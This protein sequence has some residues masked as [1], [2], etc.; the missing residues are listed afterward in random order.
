MLQTLSVRNFALIE[1]LELDFPSGITVFTGETGAGKSILMDAL[2]MVLGARASVDYIRTGTE[3]FTLTAQFE[4]TDNTELKQL[5]AEQNLAGE[6]DTL[7]IS[8]RLTTDGRGQIL[9]NGLPTPLRVL[10]AIGMLVAEIHGQHDNYKLLRPEYQL[11]VLDAYEPAVLAQKDRYRR[12]YRAWREAVDE[13]R[14][15]EERA[16]EAAAQEERWRRELSEIDAAKLRP[17]EEEELARTLQRLE[18]AE[19]IAAALAAAENLLTGA[20]GAAELLAEA[21]RETERA[22]AYDEELQGFVAELQSA[23]ITATEAGRSLA[24][25]MYRLEFSPRT[26]QQLQEREQELRSL[27]R[28]YGED[29]AAVIAYA[30]ETRRALAAVEH[31]EEERQ[32]L[33]TATEECRR[34]AE[35][36]RERLNDLRWQAAERFTTEILAILADLDLRESRLSFLLI[37]GD[38]LTEI[39]LAEA[40][41][42]FSANPGEPEKP[43]AQ[44]ASG[45]ELAR[46]S[47]AFKSI[48]A[49]QT[50]GFTLVL[51]EVDVGISGNAAVRVAH[52]IREL[53]RYLQVLC[54]THLARTAAVGSRHYYL[55]KDT[56]G[57]HTQ[58]RAEL[59]T[60][61]RRV[62]ELAR[63]L[64]GDGYTGNALETVRH[65]LPA[66]L[67]E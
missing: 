41:L 15:A 66:D 62:H 61:E 29:I 67:S 46:V 10:H 34:K 20:G 40:E 44:I 31:A 23:Q 13:Q 22:A 48:V 37:P 39:G 38:T 5:L 9:V 14:R 8:R 58:T 42:M 35:A 2:G 28:K 65:W 12:A 43:L 45:G 32:Q 16:Q 52:H 4:I 1:Q 51:D 26:L 3:G 64:E 47:L 18:H 57:T 33:A 30:D 24:E 53:G 49:A 55:Y 17:E 50:P 54:I 6:D 63:M 60:G 21:E 11:A 59:L 25:Y 27:R 7:I 19:K 56:D 36:E